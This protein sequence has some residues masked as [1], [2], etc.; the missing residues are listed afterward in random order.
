MNYATI[1]L[2][3][4]DRKLPQQSLLSDIRWTSRTECNSRRLGPFFDPRDEERLC[5]GKDL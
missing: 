3:Q 4:A 5:N 1:A 2:L